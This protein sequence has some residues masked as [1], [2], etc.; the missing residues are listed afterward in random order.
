LKG[1]SSP[2]F[3][4]SGGDSDNFT[5]AIPSEQIHPD[6]AQN[7]V[8]TGETAQKHL[9]NR[10]TVVR[11]AR[12]TKKQRQKPLFEA[13]PRIRRRASSAADIGQADRR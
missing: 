6:A 4:I 7:P 1:I 9:N 5:R 13:A 8:N 2:L 12:H 10:K 3:R 11:E